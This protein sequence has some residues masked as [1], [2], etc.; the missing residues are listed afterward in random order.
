MI[1]VI[2]RFCLENDVKSVFWVIRLYI[3]KYFISHEN[4]KKKQNKGTAHVFYFDFLS[5]SHLGL[6]LFNIF[7]KTRLQYKNLIFESLKND[8]RLKR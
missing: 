5:L 6:C 2:E 4:E 7:L 3:A 1:I 8:K